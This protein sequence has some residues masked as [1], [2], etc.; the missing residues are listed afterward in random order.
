M[1][2]LAA[3]FPV[4]AAKEHQEDETKAGPYGGDRHRH[5][6]E[7]ERPVQEDGDEKGQCPVAFPLAWVAEYGQ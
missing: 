7:V 6:E 2:A 5:Q 3:V 4:V 1:N